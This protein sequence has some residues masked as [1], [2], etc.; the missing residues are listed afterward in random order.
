MPID[1]EAFDALN[2]LLTLPRDKRERLVRAAMALEHAGA[3]ISGGTT[4]PADMA[5]D[6]IITAYNVQTARA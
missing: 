6:H 3:V 2:W 1:T 4:R 5:A